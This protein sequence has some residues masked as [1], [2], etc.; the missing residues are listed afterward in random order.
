ML[1]VSMGDLIDYFGSATDT[2]SIILYIESVA[3]AREFMSAARA[4]ARVKP[5][6]AFKSG[7]FTESAQA[8]AALPSATSSIDTIHIN[9]APQVPKSSWRCLVRHRK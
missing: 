2:R 6:V 1:D 7:R 4:F 3:N 8:A 9:F 5:I